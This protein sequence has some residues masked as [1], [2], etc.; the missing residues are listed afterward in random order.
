M[1]NKS[2]LRWCFLY[3]R[4]INGLI[5]NSMI[6]FILPVYLLRMRLMHIKYFCVRQDLY[7]NT[8][9]S[10]LI[11]FNKLNYFGYWSEVRSHYSAA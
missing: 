11:L 1:N 8:N 2:Q 3:E 4:K 6:I 9:E 5:L 10:L 7:S